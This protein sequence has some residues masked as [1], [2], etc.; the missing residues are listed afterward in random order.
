MTVKGV[1]AYLYLHFAF[2][3]FSPVILLDQAMTGGRVS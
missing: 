3:I 2:R 1:L